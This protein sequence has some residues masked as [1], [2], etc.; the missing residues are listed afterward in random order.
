[1]GWKRT[2]LK[3]KK[4]RTYPPRR[5]LL[6]HTTRHSDVFFRWMLITVYRKKLTRCRVIHPFILVPGPCSAVKQS[7]V[8]MS[9]CVLRTSN[10]FSPLFSVFRQPSIMFQMC[11]NTFYLDCSMWSW[12]FPQLSIS[13]YTDCTEVSSDQMA[14][15]F[16]NVFTCVFA[17]AYIFSVATYGCQNWTCNESLEERITIWNEML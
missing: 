7:P 4:Q 15:P 8:S 10:K 3:L 12:T 5:T 17:R 2:H 11:S 16:Y 6:L 14:N 9:C 1:M 13:S